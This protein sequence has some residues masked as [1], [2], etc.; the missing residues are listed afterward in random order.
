M[1]FRSVSS[2]VADSQDCVTV[3]SND[4][5]RKRID[6]QDCAQSSQDSRFEK[7]KPT[8][9]VQIRQ[10]DVGKGVAVR[11]VNEGIEAPLEDSSEKESKEASGGKTCSVYKE[12]ELK[13]TESQIER[14]LKKTSK[15]LNMQLEELAVMDRNDSVK[16][17]CK[18]VNTLSV[19]SDQAKQQEEN[20]RRSTQT[21]PHFANLVNSSTDEEEEEERCLDLSKTGLDNQKTNNIQQDEKVSSELT[22]AEK[23][24]PNVNETMEEGSSQIKAEPEDRDILLASSPLIASKSDPLETEPLEALLNMFVTR[25]DVILSDVVNSSLADESISS[26]NISVEKKLANSYSCP[27]CLKCYYSDNVVVQDASL[28]KVAF[29]KVCLSCVAEAND[30]TL[31]SVADEKNSDL[32]NKVK[33]EPEDEFIEA[34]AQ[35]LSIAEVQTSKLPPFKCT[36]CEKSFD[37]KDRL[38]NHERVHVKP[39]SDSKR[40]KRRLLALKDQVMLEQRL[41]S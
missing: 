32:M 21:N 24:I 17:V 28:I 25:D 7:R 31:P 1:F 2:T 20:D 3:P 30:E 10:C 38:A 14:Q 33:T 27:I 11:Y 23:F 37:R 4:G 40:A 5:D 6:S 26:T 15:L 19:Q 39:K 34:A 18:S 22:A 29:I 41:V 9:P 16:R 35:T 13:E 36:M 12:T 8:R